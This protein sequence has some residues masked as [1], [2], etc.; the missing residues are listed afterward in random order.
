MAELAFR[1]GIMD[2]IRIREPRFD[3]Q[4]YLF[5]LSALEMC[6]AQLTV[7]R[8]IT[9]V[10]LANA[11]RELALERY[12]LMARVVL[13]HLERETGGGE[14]GRVLPLSDPERT[15]HAAGAVDEPGTA[16]VDPGGRH[17]ATKLLERLRTALGHLGEREDRLGVDRHPGLGPLEAVL[18]EDLLVV[19]DDLVVDADHRSV[20]DRMVVGPDHGV[21]LGV[22]AHVNEHLARVLRDLDP[23]EELARA[24]ALLVDVDAAAAV[25]IRVPDRVR[26]AL[27]NTGQQSLR[28]ER[29]LDVALSTQTESGDSA[30]GSGARRRLGRLA[31]GPTA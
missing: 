17:R 13:D 19:Q 7:R 25:A 11:C 14:E 2:R 23:V 27:G 28:C 12:G 20:P 1:E 24:G 6:Q 4:A 21:A 18:G 29:P 22:V 31:F 30:R 8:H 5:V 10:E 3:E 15:A 26:A 9:G 16:L